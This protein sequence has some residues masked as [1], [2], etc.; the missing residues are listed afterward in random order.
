MC[1]IYGDVCV[2]VFSL[3]APVTR[4]S[5]GWHAHNRRATRII[6]S[7]S[8]SCVWSGIRE[9]ETCE[10]SK[11]KFVSSVRA[12]ALS[13]SS[14]SLGNS[15][16]SNLRPLSV[17]EWLFEAATVSADVFGR[18]L[19]GAYCGYCG[20]SGRRV[21]ICGGLLFHC[22]RWYSSAAFCLSMCSCDTLP[23]L[24]SSFLVISAATLN[25]TICCHHHNQSLSQRWASS[26]SIASPSS[27]F[28]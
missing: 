14:S 12:F 7:K 1:N 17:F 15:R 8:E 13:S 5:V 25:I 28:S 9:K 18:V 27:L 16:W 10:K 19:K 21:V 20:R 2:W 6:T 23:H 3:L 22:L 24:P 4:M 11:W 26:S